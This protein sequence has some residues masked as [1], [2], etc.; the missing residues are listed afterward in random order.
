MTLQA[1]MFAPNQTAGM[2]ITLPSGASYTSDANGLIT[3]NAGDIVGLAQAGCSLVP[4]RPVVTL[5]TSGY[6]V[7][8]A[9]NVLP[10]T[11][12]S[13]VSYAYTLAAP[14]FLGLRTTIVQPAAST[15]LST[16]TSS[17]SVIGSSYTVLTFAGALASIDL[18]AVGSTVW[19]IGAQ[20][21]T[22]SSA[23]AAITYSPAS[24]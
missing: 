4:D 12:G 3:A 2:S 1:K 19:Q 21:A 6:I 23:G 13:T 24:S 17:G 20:R 8:G 9:V 18:D 14:A 15:A 16:V 5:S 11:A 10:S 22:T 7:Q